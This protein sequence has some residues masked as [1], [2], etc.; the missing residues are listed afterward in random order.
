MHYEKSSSLLP[1]WTANWGT[2]RTQN[3]AQQWR[4]GEMYWGPALILVH[5]PSERPHCKPPLKPCS[6]GHASQPV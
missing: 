6:L 5:H 1:E 3:E 4:P 2:S